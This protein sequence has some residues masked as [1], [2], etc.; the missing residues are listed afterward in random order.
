MYCKVLLY[1]DLQGV[2]LTRSDL[3]LSIWISMNRFSQDSSCDV[4]VS[5]AMNV[6]KFQFGRFQKIITHTSRSML[7]VNPR[8]VQ[9]TIG[10]VKSHCLSNCRRFEK[11]MNR[12]T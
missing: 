10:M 1:G 4:K 8:K 7:A 6:L 12:L 9:S 11:G 5:C 3:C 2:G